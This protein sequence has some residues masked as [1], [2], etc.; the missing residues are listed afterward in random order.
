MVQPLLIGE[1]E[2]TATETLALVDPSTGEIFGSVARASPSQV[3]AAVE[4]ARSCWELQWRDTKPAVRARALHAVAQAI[5]TS[6]EVL[7][8]LGAQDAGMPLPMARADVENA[9]RYF[10]FY[11]GVADKHGGASIPLGPDY[12]DFTVREPWGVC[13]VVTPF[14][15]P[16]QLAARSIAPALAT[17]NTVV[18]KPAEQAPLP[19]LALARIVRASDVPAGA[20]SVVPGLGHD[21]GQ[22][23]IEHPDV[24]HITF[25]GSLSTGQR[26]MEAASRAL[27]PVTL[28]LGGKSPQVVFA[29]ADLDAAVAAIVASALLTA[30]QVC[31]AG[32]RV[33]AEA[34]VYEGL[35]ERLVVR[36]REIRVGIASESPEMGPLVSAEQR[37]RVLRA[38]ADVQRDGA[39]LRTGGGRPADARLAGGYFVEPTVFA[40][41]A[42]T[43]VAREEIFGPVLAVIEFDGAEE[44]LAIA[45]DSPY[46]LVAGVWTRDIG[47]ALW[48]ASRVRAGQVFVNNYGS[49]GGV[50]LPFGGYRRSGFGREKGLAAL[51]E[52]TQIKNVCVHIASG[53]KLG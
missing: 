36:A 48:L 12:V 7:A 8:A 4:A 33:L 51:T 52:Y 18:L 43:A 11:A 35:L 22:R 29:D 44:A 2:V 28:E 39:Q 45:N 17:G 1:D 23:L 49:G 15:V 37:D 40:A 32:T 38:I 53:P 9:A 31:S 16:F 10:E 42:D 46:G 26:I 19:A 34:S 47:R 27:T 6:A 20:L 41:P 24:D 30:G 25:T 5:R 21:T 13:A 50:E 3:D 14:N